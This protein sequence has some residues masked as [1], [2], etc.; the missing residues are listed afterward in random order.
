MTEK[1]KK[2]AVKH[3]NTP[4]NRLLAAYL[5]FICMW[6][7]FHLGYTAVNSIG[8]IGGNAKQQLTVA[9]FT[10]VDVEVVNENTII[11]STGDSQLIYTGPIRNMRIKCSFSIDPG[12]FVCFY[13][14]RGN[15]A[16]G[17]HRMRYAKIIGDCYWFEFPP[18]TKQIRLD[19]GVEPSI[20]VVFDSITINTP[21][22][23]TVAG[24]TAGDGF[25]LLTVPGLIFMIGE[26]ALS[27]VKN[28]KERDERQ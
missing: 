23:S 24:I 13:N 25:T 14:Y 1:V 8:F 7:M 11:N 4:Q 9:D 2:F 26:T 12:E 6:S 28:K 10:P 18:G 17:I 15:N 19:T 20:T 16:F 21:T 27:L 22:L 3:L 5:L